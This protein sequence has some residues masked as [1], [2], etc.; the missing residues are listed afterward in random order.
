MPE[1]VD[2]LSD[3]GR[4]PSIAVDADGLPH[5]AYL[6]LNEKLAEGEIPPARPLTLPIIPAVLT[7]NF[8]KEGLWDHGSVV[9]TQ[10][11]ADPLPLKKTDLVAIAIDPRGNRSVAFTEKGELHFAVESGGDFGAPEKIASGSFTGLSAA[12][13]PKGT[14]WV[15]WIEGGNLRVATKAGDSWSIDT[16]GPAS[17]SRRLP[18]TTS[19][20]ASRSGPL[21]AYTGPG[22]QGPMLAKRTGGA[23]TSES[24]DSGGGGY[25][26]SLALDA[27]GYPH[28]AYYTSRGEVRHAH[29]VGAPWEVTP[30]AQAGRTHPAGWS[31]SIAL[32]KKGTHYIA[33]YD[34]NDDQI[35]LATN[36]SGKFK[37]IP[38]TG[39]QQGELPQV[40]VAPDGSTVYVAWYDHVNADLYVGLYGV[41]GPLD[42]GLA[43]VPP[44]TPPSGPTGGPSG[45]C[46][47][48]DNV[49]INAPSGAAVGGF[50]E[51]SVTAPAKGVA[52]CF[53]NDDSGVAH[54]VGIFSADPLQ[55]PSAKTIF[56]GDLV[57][58]STT[59][60]YDVGAVP[61]GSYFFHCDVHPT[62]MTGTL[63][64]K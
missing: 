38:V 23:W 20:E 37:E 61:A 11:T 49:T 53:E 8:S 52:I 1:A 30:I 29:S 56:T 58:G 47:P 27:D 45:G 4:S 28:V 16:V 51:T 18:A 62:T 54:N 2:T 13:D 46:S 63:T 26:I 32:D 7:A 17:S 64:V 60:D 19:I 22:G 44:Q 42:V 31:A 6:G 24:I 59:V 55:D 39:T 10:N 35:R 21:L 36:S 34:A 48:D 15:A 5:L 25:G 9:A 40:A 50:K 14:P 3:T 12:V 43:A 41:N 33:W 57:T